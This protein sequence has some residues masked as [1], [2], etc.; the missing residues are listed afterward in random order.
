[1]D[2]DQANVAWLCRTCA[3]SRRTRG[4]LPRARIGEFELLGILGQGGFGV[5]YEARDEQHGFHA[6]VKVLHDYLAEDDEIR[7]RFTDREAAA[8]D[9]IQHPN[10]VRLLSRGDDHGTL[11]IATEFA[12]GGDAEALITPNSPIADTLH[13]GADLFTGLAAIHDRDY[14]HRD[15]KPSNVLL[16]RSSLPYR[17]MIGDFGLAKQIGDRTLTLSNTFWGTPH[18]ASPQHL[19]D[20]KRATPADDLYSVAATLYHVLAGT[21]ATEGIESL[22]EPEL[23]TRAVLNNQ[24]IPLRQYRPEV[25]AEI[26]RTIDALVAHSPDAR[27]RSS[28]KTLAVAF[29]TA[30]ASAQG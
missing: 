12:R 1:M 26:A 13:L 5:V 3:E 18:Y 2:S 15:L 23:V 22:S 7:T 9:R 27:A 30:A 19:L 6:A 21:F 29:R 14:V 16:A 28:A 25:P 17:G 24:R 20:W 10:V 4:D 11:Y 8:G